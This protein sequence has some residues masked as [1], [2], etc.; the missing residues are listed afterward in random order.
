MNL[1]SR[2]LMEQEKLETDPVAKAVFPSPIAM[3]IASKYEEETKLSI[4]KKY[5]L[6][7]R[8][9]FTM[10]IRKDRLL[11]FFMDR[12]GIRDSPLMR[13]IFHTLSGEYV[14]LISFLLL[15]LRITYTRTYTCTLR[16]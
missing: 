13:S 6:L 9:Q 10:S 11:R 1:V 12:D 14:V 4:I 2:K 7:G 8:P 5:G 16:P 3:G 15:L